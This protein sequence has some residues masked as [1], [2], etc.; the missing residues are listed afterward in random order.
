[1][2]MITLLLSLIVT[3]LYTKEQVLTISTGFA[4]PEATLVAT[5]LQEGFDRAGIDLIYQVLPNQRS[6]I[7]ANNGVNDGEAAR[8]WEIDKSYP[9]LIRVGVQTH[10][11]QLVVLSRKKVFIDEL[12]DLKKYHVGII[13]GMKIAEELVR[14]EAPL[15]L[16][17]ATEHLSLIKMLANDRL[18]VIITNRIGLFTGLI[19]SHKDE[20]YLRKE[21]LISRKLYMYLHKRHKALVPILEKA[22]RSMIEDGTHQSIQESFLRNMK[23]EFQGSVKVIEYD[24]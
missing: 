5:V 13:R 19:G 15:S 24:H 21:P 2:R 3:T 14:Q 18:D 8:I 17:E 10:F 11:I 16:T 9:N 4:Q 20:F 6:L 12:S 7:N 23:T 1:M 22:F